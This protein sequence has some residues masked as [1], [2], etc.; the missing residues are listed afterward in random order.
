MNV[1]TQYQNNI[2][3][4]VRYKTLEQQQAEARARQRKFD[5]HWL[6]MAQVH[7]ELSKDTTKVGCVIVGRNDEVRTTGYNGLPR[8]AQDDVPD[9]L[10][11]PE[12]YLW[13]EHAERNAIYN[14]AR[15]GVP[16][17]GSTAYT[18]LHPCMDCTR[19]LI[20]SGIKRVVTYKPDLIK[21]E[22]WVDQFEKSRTLF[23][24]CGVKLEFNE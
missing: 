18:T 8:G 10:V 11:R 19:A 23:H 3:D 7:S 21:Y 14:A 17:S 1:T 12:K 2:L 13:Y 15:I 20:Q 16:L 9:R 6:S 4:T 24:E 5:N 22:S